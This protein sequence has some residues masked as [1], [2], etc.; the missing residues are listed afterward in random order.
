MERMSGEVVSCLR[1]MSEGL[2]AGEVI[3]LSARGGGCSGMSFFFAPSKKTDED[4]SWGV[5]GE[6]L[7]VMDWATSQYVGARDVVVEDGR[8]VC[9]N[10]GVCGCPSSSLPVCG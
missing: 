2:G 8:L 5:E 4:V 6:E 1:K 10:K 7:L 3:R 9:R